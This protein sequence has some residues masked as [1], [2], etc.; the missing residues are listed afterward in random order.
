MPDHPIW[1][2]CLTA[3]L[4]RSLHSFRLNITILCEGIPY[5]IVLVFFWVVSR[6]CTRKNRCPGQALVCVR[7]CACCGS[8]ALLNTLLPLLQHWELWHWPPLRA[9]PTAWFCEFLSCFWKKKARVWR[10]CLF[11]PKRKHLVLLWSI[12]VHSRWMRIAFKTRK[13]LLWKYKTQCF[14]FTFLLYHP[15]LRLA[16]MQIY[17]RY[18][19][20]WISSF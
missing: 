13:L 10:S 3:V 14:H 18:C 12:L 20:C 11:K 17:R 15:P 2:C 9:V 16:L 8:V 6:A 7:L 1:C 19:C 4:N 5:F